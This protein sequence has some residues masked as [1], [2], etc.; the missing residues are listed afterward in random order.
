MKGA[1]YAG[2]EPEPPCQGE[3]AEADDSRHD[4]RDPPRDMRPPRASSPE[5]IDRHA[6]WQREH[7][8]AKRHQQVVQPR[9]ERE[10]GEHAGS[11]RD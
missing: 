11:D 3:Q 2:V 6:Q 9:I 7:R 4:H 8:D 5:G 1:E 10:R